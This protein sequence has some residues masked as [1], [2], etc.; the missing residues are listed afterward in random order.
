MKSDVLTIGQIEKRFGSEWILVEYPL[1]D[2]AMQVQGGT[3]L[4]HSKD[5]D[6]V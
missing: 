5:R 2:A 4:F 3:V 6:A 1:V